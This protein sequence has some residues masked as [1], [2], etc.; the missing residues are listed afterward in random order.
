MARLWKRI[1]GRVVMTVSKF[2]NDCRFSLKLAAYRMIDDLCGRFGFKKIS[3]VF[4]HKKD[5][6]IIEF[7][8]RELQSVVDLYKEDD[9]L[10]EPQEI[11]PIWV[12]WWSGEETAPTLVKQC[13]RSIRANAGTHP[14]HL[15]TKDNY[16]EFLEIPDYMLKKVSKGE[17]GFAHLADYIR[18]TLL[19]QWGGL[20]LDATIFCAESLPDELFVRSFFTCRSAE[21]PNCHYLSRMRWVTFVLGGWKGNLFFRYLKRAFEE[22]WKNQPAAI[23]YLM[24]D[25]LIE[26]GYRDIPGIRKLIDTVPENNLRRDDL[27]AAMNRAAS[28]EEWNDVV[29]PDTVLYKLS[30][31]E[32]YRET[33]PDGQDS[34]YRYF[35]NKEI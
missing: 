6:W 7:L 20:W 17:M 4:H 11:A 35:L 22:Y 30:W 32:T 8:K 26:L 25:S 3:K 10:G 29:R 21:Q 28:P 12:C 9:D 27:Q 19:A 15:I 18:V 33:T 13:I 16:Q 5:E 23:D 2:R 24:F 34:I 14:V 31:R 1:K